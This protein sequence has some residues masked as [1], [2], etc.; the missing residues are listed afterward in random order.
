[1]QAIVFCRSR[2]IFG[3]NIGSTATS[4]AQVRVRTQK[5][6]V[7]TDST[8]VACSTARSRCSPGKMAS[9]SSFATVFPTNY[10][11]LWYR[12]PFLVKFKRFIGS[13]WSSR[14]FICSTRSSSSNHDYPAAS[15]NFCTS[16]SS[17]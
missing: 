7:S 13:S 11:T 16:T 12:L 15:K 10:I 4:N 5:N 3:I 8:T 14:S 2:E 1:M 17:S 6:P 9:I